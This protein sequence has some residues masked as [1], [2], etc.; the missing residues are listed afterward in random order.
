MWGLSKINHEFK[1]WGYYILKQIPGR[2]GCYI[3]YVLIVKNKRGYC[4]IWEGVQ[5][6]SISNLFLGNNVSINRGCIINCAGVVE[7]GDDSMLGPNVLVYSQSHKFRDK[8]LKINQQGYVVKKVKIG[9]NCWIGAGAIIL[10]GVTIE[11]NSVIAA[12]SVVV[13]NVNANTLI[14][15][16]RN[17]FDFDLFNS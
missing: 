12:G 15:N 4:K 5:I 2:I 10:P 7:I 1:L 13:K 14:I 16:K 8:S 17:R 6:D 9:K 11:D 3:R